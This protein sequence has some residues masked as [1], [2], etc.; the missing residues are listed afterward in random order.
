MAALGFVLEK[1]LNKSFLTSIVYTI[2]LRYPPTPASLQMLA[3]FTDLLS[4]FASGRGVELDEIII[5]GRKGFQVGQCR[6]RYITETWLEYNLL[7]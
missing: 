6:N 1:T 2:F 5:G 7:D 3:R 4:Q